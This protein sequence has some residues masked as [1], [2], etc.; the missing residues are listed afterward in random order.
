[1]KIYHNFQWSFYHFYVVIS[2]ISCAEIDPRNPT[3]RQDYSSLHAAS[4]NYKYTVQK[5]V[6][7]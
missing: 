2:E 7:F 4:Q 3:I 1:M 5:N 6:V